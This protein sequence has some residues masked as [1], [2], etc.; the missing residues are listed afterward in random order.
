M[1][2]R[3]YSNG[4]HTVSILYLAVRHRRPSWFVKKLLG[5]IPA[6]EQWDPVLTVAVS[7]DYAD[8]VI[9]TLIEKGANV[10]APYTTYEYIRNSGNGNVRS[11]K[12]HTTTA[13]YA[14]VEKKRLNVVKMLLANGADADWKSPEGKSI[15]D[16][17]T[18]SQIRALLK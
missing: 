3:Y 8:D 5:K 18:T 16:L 7:C 2:T 4:E 6:F 15:R 17:G 1:Q 11:R 13:L 12:E 10:N 14:A 9:K